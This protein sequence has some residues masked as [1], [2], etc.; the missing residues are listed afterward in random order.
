MDS[1]AEMAGLDGG[2]LPALSTAPLE[3]GGMKIFVW[4]LGLV[5]GQSRIAGGHEA[6]P[7]KY[8]FSASIFLEGDF[9]C[10]GVFV[11]DRHLLTAAHCSLFPLKDYTVG[12]HR[13]NLTRP[14]PEECGETHGVEAIFTNPLYQAETNMN[15]IAVFRL[16]TPIAGDIGR[17]GM[18]DGRI[19]DAPG[20]LATAIGWGWQKDG[21]PISPVLREVQIPIVGYYDCY[22]AWK[23]YG[24]PVTQYSHVCAAGQGDKDVCKGDSGGALFVYRSDIPI[25]VGTTSFGYPCAHKDFPTIFT[26]TASFYN[27]IRSHIS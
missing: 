22:L 25:L 7:F 2:T 11:N 12:F 24:Y 26:R 4:T 3:D 23:P 13:H 6:E 20:T 15:D 19:A 21:G 10:G 17:I 27:F 1:M 8:K 9:I 16:K 14:A 18:D 5:A